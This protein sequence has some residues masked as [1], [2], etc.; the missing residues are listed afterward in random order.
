MIDSERWD[1]AVEA[2]RV[3]VELIDERVGAGD[4]APQ[5][6]VDLLHRARSL[7]FRAETATCSWADETNLVQYVKNA[8]SL[9]DRAR[10]IVTQEVV[11]ELNV[12]PFEALRLFTVNLEVSSKIAEFASENFCTNAA[13]A[14]DAANGKNTNAGEQRIR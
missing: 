12:P 7:R 10:S 8:K 11:G 6:I 13:L 4:E 9:A 1:E 3:L 2:T 5:F 14:A